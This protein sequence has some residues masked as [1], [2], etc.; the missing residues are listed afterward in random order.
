MLCFCTELVTV[1][2]RMHN[3]KPKRLD[4]MK[5]LTLFFIMTLA[6]SAPLLSQAGQVYKW[7]DENGNTQFSQFPPEDE[8]Q[9]EQL[10]IK[11]QKSTNASQSKEKLKSMRQKLLESSVD[12][13]TENEEEKL[14]KEKA[15]LMAQ[16]CDKANQRLRD[17]ENNGRIYKT[18]ENGE[19]HWFDE[20]ERAQSIKAAKDQVKEFCSK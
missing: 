16:N 11:T 2:L 4:Q 7:V 20:K 10:D 19:R 15:E 5:Q 9:A 6:I 8:Q 13:N 17:L 1:A 3:D 14:D 18:L 12:R